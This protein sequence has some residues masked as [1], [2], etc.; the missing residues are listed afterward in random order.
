MMLAG[1]PLLQPL[2]VGT[3]PLIAQQRTMVTL[4]DLKL[5]IRS[6]TNI[7][8]ITATMKLVATSKLKAAQRNMDI[9]R[10]FVSAVNC[11][12]EIAEAADEMKA[13]G[14]SAEGSHRVIPITSD[15]GLCGSVN[16]SVLR[17]SR[18]LARSHP[19]DVPFIFS[20]IGSKGRAGLMREF[21]KSI[22][23]TA[24]EIGEKKGI[25]FTDIVPF[26]EAITASTSFDRITLV[27]NK[28]VSMV[29]FETEKVP[30][31][32]TAEIS[33]IDLTKYEF[34]SE[35]P[36]ATMQSYFEWYLGSTLFARV[37]ENTACEMS[38][39]MNS[40]DNATRNAGEIIRV[41]KIKYNRGRQAAITSELAEIIG[42][43]EAIK[44][45]EP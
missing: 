18:A 40:M 15:R 7:R 19:K 8:K 3:R 27:C 34:E 6:V 5:R 36:E 23:F 2:L 37:I 17:A 28:F 25:R 45:E 12:P 9:A 29:A 26:S 44:E 20:I 10:P 1:K 39:R 11:I 41:L 22:D 14:G 38:A 32:T 4:S 42:G 33:R 13:S 35:D 16:G 30:L 31:L 21:G 24:Y 43:A